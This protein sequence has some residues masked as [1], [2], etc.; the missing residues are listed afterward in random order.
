MSDFSLMFSLWLPALIGGAFAFAFGACAGSF[1]NVVAWRLPNG[2]SIVSPPSRCPKCGHKLGWRENLPIIGWL[3]LAGKCKSCKLPISIRYPCVE[4]L[5]ACIFLATFVLFYGPFDRVEGWGLHAA[6]PWW[7]LQ[8]FSRSWS[9]FIVVVFALSGLL[10][11]TLM[12]ADTMTIDIGIPSV[13]SAVAFV[14]WT[15][16][17]FLP[18]SRS[19]RGLVPIDPATWEVGFA[20]FG[21]MVGLGVS[22]WLLKTGRLR[23]S[24]ADWHEVVGEGGDGAN[25]PNSRREMLAELAFL[26]PPIAGAGL[27][28]FLPS[29]FN[30]HGAACQPVALLGGALLGWIVGGGIVWLV[31]ILGTF[32]FGREAMGLGDVH[33]LAAVGAAFGWRFALLTFFIAPFSGLT[34]SLLGKLFGGKEGM[35]SGFFGKELPYGPHLALAAMVLL[36][37]RPAI[38]NVGVLFEMLASPVAVNIPVERAH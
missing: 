1:I 26:A 37:A 22:L 16:Q 31:R 27:A 38:V 6:S 29:L 2:E 19:L 28:C 33:L 34:W 12:D 20:C 3:M 4:L 36:F 9:A 25:Y 17:G 32:A 11:M 15:V 10:A 18:E 5:L 35:R 14:G 7:H 13:V 24:F 23:R 21:L 8:G 30:L